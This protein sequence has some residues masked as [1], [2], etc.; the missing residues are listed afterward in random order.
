MN[1]IFRYNSETMCKLILEKVMIEDLE[2]SVTDMFGLHS[3]KF[4][5]FYIDDNGENIVLVNQGSVDYF[6]D[7]IDSDTAYLHVMS[8]DN[9]LFAQENVP[10][11]KKV[12]IRELVGKFSDQLNQFNL[13]EELDKI[14]KYM[15][16]YFN[17]PAIVEDIIEFLR[18]NLECLDETSV[19]FESLSGAPISRIEQKQNP[20]NNGEYSECDLWEKNKST[21]SNLTEKDEAASKEGKAKKRKYL[22][23]IAELEKESCSS[24]HSNYSNTKRLSIKEKKAEGMFS[25]EQLFDNEQ[26][27]LR[28]SDGHM[29]KKVELEI[30]LK[31]DSDVHMNKKP[32][33]TGSNSA[34]LKK[35]KSIIKNFK[36]VFH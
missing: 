7:N 22:N 27:S 5:L 33:K 36:S 15:S 3:K 19:S 20:W 10:I 29:L 9:G 11:I 14:E 26:K 17:D 2:C 25:S 34:F 30:Q 35:I 13:N 24:F 21:R 23:E 1:F 6:L 16:Q 18:N 32:K 31:Y 28:V 8:V 12:Y 4:V